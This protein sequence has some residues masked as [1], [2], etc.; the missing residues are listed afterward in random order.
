MDIHKR[1]LLFFD[2]LLRVEDVMRL[3][4]KTLIWT[5]RYLGIVLSAVF[6]MWFLTGIGMIYARGMPRLTP[7]V[8]LARL[9]PLNFENVEISPAEAAE[10]A[11]A[12]NPGR[13][14]LTTVL[15]RPAYQFS[16]RGTRTVFADNGETLAELSASSARR[17]AAQFMDLPE[18]QIPDA[19]I[20]SEPDQW[21]LQNRFPIYKF[22]VRD[23]AGTHLYVSPQSAEV[24]QLTTRSS[25]WLA[26]VS[27]IPH[28]L[29]FRSLRLDV[30]IW[31][32]VVV[33]A[34][35]LG[36]IVAAAGIFLGILH[37]KPSKPLRVSRLSSYIP[38]RG[39]LRWH[40][41]LGLVFGVLTLTWVFS[42]LLSMEP[43]A[44]TNSDESLVEAGRRAFPEGFGDLSR[45]PSID[46]QAL[47]N[48]LKGAAAKEVEFASIVDEPHYIVRGASGMAPI[49]GT[50]DGGHQPYY[51]MRGVDPERWVI[52]ANGMRLRE[53]PF[54]TETIQ[55]RLATALPDIAVV[56]TTWL[57]SYDWY[58]YSRDGRAPLP[59]LRLKMA[60]A[61]STWLY[62]D[63]QVNQ[64]VGRV[65]R[66]NRVERW[67]YNGLH[68][69]DF[70]FLYYNRPLWDGVVIVLSLGGAAL[71]AIGVIL[72]VRR[73]TR[74]VRKTA[75]S[76][77]AS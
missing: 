74:G 51:V 37:F 21:T 55:G 63:P 42:G 46:T 16:A 31:N 69:L 58:Y 10:I 49:P 24:V 26:W 9:L 64:I 22:E 14:T 38:Y 61:D 20:L 19:A 1:T 34:A 71:S 25:R 39:W 17:V 40:F 73:V 67:L 41:A 43:W 30:G 29:Y 66:L 50:P 7:E 72:G 70:P 5:H 75:T 23:D 27:T 54:P 52:A 76:M 36:C 33:W 32:S 35:G 15:D 8:R 57:D 45:F 77:T 65:N 2:R 18:S 60:D 44:W 48:V 62:V 12:G 11:G 56:E 47:R 68:N 28:F 13:L 53:E 4:R 6:L 3:L 59:V